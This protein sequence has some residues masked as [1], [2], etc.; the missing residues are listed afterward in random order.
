MNAIVLPALLLV[1]AADEKPTPKLPVGKGTTVVSGPINKNGYIDYEAALN[2]IL[3]KG[4]TAENNANALL[5]KAFGPKPEGSNMPPE[6]FKR[7]GIAEPPED[8]DHFIN[9]HRFLRD[10]L[11]INPEDF[12]T[13]YNQQDQAR[14]RPWTAKDYPDVAAWLKANDKPLAIVLEATKRPR[15]FNPLVSRRG[16]DDPSSLIGCL[17]PSVQMCRELASALTCRAMLRLGEGKEAEA[18]ADL[19]ACH[20]LA[21]HLSHGGTL[22][23]TLVSYAIHAIACGAT[24]T[25]IEHANLTAEQ[26]SAR[27]KEL[28]A[29][30]PMT[31]LA[32]KIDI[33]ERLMGID[34]VQMIRSGT[35]GLNKPDEEEQKVLDM[36]DWGAILRT[37][38]AAYDRMSAAMRIKDR[39]AREKEFELIEVDYTELTK[40]YPD[41]DIK[42]LLKQVGAKKL[43]SKQLGDILM[44][45]LMPAVRKV[46]Y[47]AD[48]MEQVDRNLHIAL[49]LAAYRKAEGRYPAKLADL[50]PKYLTA[51]PTDVFSGK[52]LIYKPGENGYLFYSVGLNGKDD[53]GQWYGDTPPGDDPGVRVPRPERKKNP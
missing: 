5:W 11:Q 30:A 51:V 19:L 15:Y 49:A 24:L 8:G 1:C 47:A 25:Y 10:V 31:P 27:L 33:S 46:Q 44:G 38:N 12:Q 53:G 28:R 21:R 4:V 42:K 3:G 17:L 32:D 14:A 2:D 36:I 22:I 18:W 48:R 39:V 50:A 52:D 29:L 41:P 37:M 26:Y 35:G 40:K 9:T 13:V 16:P 6:Y 43:V 23:E 7:L 34:A 20:R 45:L